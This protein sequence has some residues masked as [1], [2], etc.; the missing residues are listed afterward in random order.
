VA[1]RNVGQGK[2]GHTILAGNR[3]PGSRRKLCERRGLG[4]KKRPA[5]AG[6]EYQARVGEWSDRRGQFPPIRDG[7]LVAMSGGMG[8]QRSTRD[9]A[10]RG[11]RTPGSADSLTGKRVLMR[12][13]TLAAPSGAKA[14]GLVALTSTTSGA[15]SLL[16]A[17]AI[18]I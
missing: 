18:R 1:A 5:L 12:P 6:I 2:R 8:R 13:R 7:P 14:S 4:G 16:S 10:V 11:T 9:P 17:P 3:E 15:N